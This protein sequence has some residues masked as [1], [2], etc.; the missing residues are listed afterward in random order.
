MCCDEFKKSDLK[1]TTTNKLICRQCSK[2]NDMVLCKVCK[3]LTD[4]SDDGKMCREHK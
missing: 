4:T 1:E 3:K 2:I